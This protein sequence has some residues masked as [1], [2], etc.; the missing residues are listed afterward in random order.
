[1]D[2]S[3]LAEI[4]KLTQAER[5]IILKIRSLSKEDMKEIYDTILNTEIEEDI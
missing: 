5:E 3:L 2:N 1:M 4:G